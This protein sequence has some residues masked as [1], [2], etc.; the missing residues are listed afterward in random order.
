MIVIAVGAAGGV[1]VTLL[2]RWFTGRKLDVWLRDN[3]RIFVAGVIAVVFSGLLYSAVHEFGHFIF[4][5]ALGGTVRSVTWTIFGN[6]EPHVSYGD[7]PPNAVPWASAGGYL[8][9]TA[10]ALVLIAAWYCRRH[11]W[12]PLSTTVLLIPAAIMLI[13]NVGV[14][15]EM[16]R[17]RSHVGKFTSYYGMGKIGEV[18]VSLSLAAASIT[19]LIAVL[20]TLKNH[21]STAS[22]MTTQLNRMARL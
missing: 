19:I 6:A 8:V 3:R 7:L 21:K 17:Q 18:I 9:P 20:L 11:R 13:C 4:A 15:T 22:G 2:V 10:L 12:S 1:F 5:V 16:L 14:A